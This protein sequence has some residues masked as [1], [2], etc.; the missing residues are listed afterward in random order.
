MLFAF[1]VVVGLAFGYND[2]AIR[3]KSS[4]SISFSVFYFVFTTHFGLR[5]R[6]VYFSL[7]WLL[8]SSVLFLS[9]MNTINIY[10]LS[11]F[12]TYHITRNIFWHNHGR[13]FIPFQAA[14]WDKIYRYISKLEGRA[15]TAK[16]KRYM[17]VMLIAGFLLL[18]SCL[19][20]VIKNPT[21]VRD[22]S[23]DPP[24]QRSETRTWNK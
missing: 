2:K 9:D 20:G 21:R 3:F 18:M 17:K 8:L 15:G 5:F 7:L 14:R 10:P 22:N 13:E 11:A 1:G 12:V 4:I 24:T 19:F 6:S 16:D 23:E